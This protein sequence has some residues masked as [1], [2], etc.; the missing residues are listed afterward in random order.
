[1]KVAPL[2]SLI[3]LAAPYDTKHYLQRRDGAM[4]MRDLTLICM[5]CKQGYPR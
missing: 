1:M 5:T 4:F 2:G 3:A